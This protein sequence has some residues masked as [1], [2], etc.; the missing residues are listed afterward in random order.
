M[1]NESGKIELK[2]LDW[3]NP[4][5]I[6]N[7]WELI[8]YIHQV[9]FL[10]LFANEVPGFSVEEHVSPLH[11]WSDNA[12]EDPWVWREIIARDE[13]IAYGK[14]FNGKAGFVSKEWFPTFAN[15]RRYGKDFDLAYEEGNVE[16]RAKKVVELFDSA[17]ELFSFEARKEAGFEKGGEKNFEGVVTALQMKS[18]LITKDFRKRRRKSDGAEYGWSIAVYTTPER[19]WGYDYITSA[20]G[21]TPEESWWRLFHRIREE[22][23]WSTDE[24]VSNVLK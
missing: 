10:P 5:R 21:Q 6:R 14:F 24:Q 16:H 1:T 22:Y 4:F 2:G 8:N 13:N 12:E 17:E 15:Y 20:Y 11:W 19:L 23:P 3:D 7:V 9:G 18:Y